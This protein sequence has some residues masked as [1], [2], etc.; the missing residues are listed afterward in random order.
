MHCCQHSML[1][2]AFYGKSTTTSFSLPSVVCPPRL[3]ST[4]RT[5]ASDDKPRPTFLRASHHQRQCRSVVVAKE[6]LVSLKRSIIPWPSAQGGRWPRRCELLSG[7]AAVASSC[8]WPSA[9]LLWRCCCVGRYCGDAAAVASRC[10]WALLR[11]DACS[12]A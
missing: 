4:I 7:D 1:L 12:T 8:C 5:R 3:S 11:R 6:T 2:M 9:M 10:C